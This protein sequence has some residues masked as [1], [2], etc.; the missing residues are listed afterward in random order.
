MTLIQVDPE[1][2]RELGAV[3]AATAEALEALD[4][5]GAP[6]WALGPCATEAA[7]E[8]CLGDWRHAR[9]QLARRLRDLGELAAVAGGAYVDTEASVGGRLLVGGR[10]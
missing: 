9:L 1:Q 10:Q 7:L 6:A 5:L 3:L 4:G 8:D 2:V